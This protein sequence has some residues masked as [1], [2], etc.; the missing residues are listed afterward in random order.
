MNCATFSSPSSFPSAS[1]KTKSKALSH[2][3]SCN[4]LN[5]SSSPSVS[6]NGSSRQQH[7]L[8]QTS[9]KNVM[10][11]PCRIP[12]PYTFDDLDNN[13]MIGHSCLSEF[14][15]KSIQKMSLDYKGHWQFS[16]GRVILK[17]HLPKIT[18]LC[19]NRVR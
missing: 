13:K 4:S 7:P 11:S 10:L 18:N 19:R 2:Y 15:S 14:S 6:F 1:P 5:W 9:P 12:H 3:C 16:D 17:M 8:H